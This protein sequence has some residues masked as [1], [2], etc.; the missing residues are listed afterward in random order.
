MKHNLDSFRSIFKKIENFIVIFHFAFC[1]VKTSKTAKM[2]K[3][4]SL[5]NYYK[6]SQN[7]LNMLK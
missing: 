2:L 5:K 4:I 6:I 3:N 7:I 1:N